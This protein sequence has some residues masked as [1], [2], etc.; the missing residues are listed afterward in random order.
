[1]ATPIPAQRAHG[2]FA[3]ADTLADTPGEPSAFMTTT[4]HSP[5]LIFHVRAWVPEP[6]ADAAQ[7]FWAAGRPGAAEPRCGT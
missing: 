7:N 3:P 5:D 4:D 2:I 6:V 1:M